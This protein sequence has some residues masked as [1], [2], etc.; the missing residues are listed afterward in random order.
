MPRI[1]KMNIFQSRPE[2]TEDSTDELLLT[3]H[4]DRA[5]SRPELLPPNLDPGWGQ[6][7]RSGGESQENAF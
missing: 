1:I 4:K 5:V 3:P 7:N 2:R 6:R